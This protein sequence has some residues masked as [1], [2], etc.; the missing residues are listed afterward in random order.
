A[1]TLYNEQADRAQAQAER[2]ARSRPLQRALEHRDR[3]ALRRIVA[4][5]A[6]YVVGARGLQAGSTPV[7]AA[8]L[9]VD[10]VTRTKHLG[11]VVATVPLDNTLIERLRSRAAFASGDLLVLLEGTR[12]AA[13]AP[14]LRGTA[15]VAAGRSATVSLAGTRYRAFVA[16]GLPGAPSARL[17]V[18]TRQGL[19]DGGAARAR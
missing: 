3:R 7:L 17:A 12:I 14:P 19:V 15:P 6:L 11:E 5:K 16:P 13:S 1:L 4:G 8:R 18:L 9:P 10:V 2:V